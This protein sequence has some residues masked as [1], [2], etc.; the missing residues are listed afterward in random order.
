MRRERGFTIIELMIVVTIVGI[1]SAISIP[2]YQNYVTRAKVAEALQLVR[3]VQ[4]A[5]IDR[6][7]LAG[8][9]PADNAA[10]NLGAPAEFR[11]QYVRSIAVA[12]GVVTVTFGDPALA[13]QTVT[14][15]PAGT[16]NAVT[17]NC[18]STLP[19][20]LKPKGCG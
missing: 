13:D 10:A 15:T 8:Q 18:T 1:I 17:W 5:V 11:G 6:Y 4:V 14:L 20:Y 19:S 7:I 2:V 3:P 9:W 12:A 16:D